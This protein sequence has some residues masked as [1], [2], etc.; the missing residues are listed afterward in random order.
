MVVFLL[1]MRSPVYKV[2]LIAPG[3]LPLKPH[4]GRGSAFNFLLQATD[5]FFVV[6]ER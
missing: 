3:S 4:T 1:F 6:A 5:L 2:R